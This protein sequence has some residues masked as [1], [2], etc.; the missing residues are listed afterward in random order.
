M[1]FVLPRPTYHISL[2]LPLTHTTDKNL[3]QM[4][5]AAINVEEG[6]ME[7]VDADALDADALDA[8]EGGGGEG[9]SSSSSLAAAVHTCSTSNISSSSSGSD[10]IEAPNFGMFLVV[11]LGVP[12]RN[13][14]L[15][16]PLCPHHFSR[17][18]LTSFL[19]PSPAYSQTRLRSLRNL[20]TF[21]QTCKRSFPS[22]VPIH[23]PVHPHSLISSFFFPVPPNPL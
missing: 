6:D 7:V 21:L 17:A 20:A 22:F 15:I 10:D 4:Q 11:G 9:A 18:L 23:P 1:S 13:S 5:A 14:T 16:L 3:P 2:P 19:C 8:E 12:T